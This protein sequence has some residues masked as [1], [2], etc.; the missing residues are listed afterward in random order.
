MLRNKW[1]LD[2]SMGGSLPVYHFERESPSECPVDSR[3][4][5]SP[6]GERGGVSVGS[7]DKGARGLVGDLTTKGKATVTVNRSPS[8]WTLN[9]P[10][11]A[12]VKLLAM[13][14]PNPLPSVV[15]F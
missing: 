10:P 14:S 11:Q 6:A 4:A 13:E 3:G 12:S 8:V 9:V 7:A 15:R 2:F 1:E 5:V